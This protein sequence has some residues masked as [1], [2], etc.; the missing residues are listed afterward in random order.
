MTKKTAGKRS[1]TSEQKQALKVLGGELKVVRERVGFSQR[2]AAE[3]ARVIDFYKQGRVRPLTPRQWGR[4]ER[5]ECVPRPATLRAVVNAV[6]WKY[7]AVRE[8]LRP[9]PDLLE[10]A[11]LKKGGDP[12]GDLLDD[13]FNYFTE[14]QQL[15]ITNII[16]LLRFRS[17]VECEDILDF[18]KLVV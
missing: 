13:K 3:R 2:E 6:G 16:D 8:L 17:A 12:I 18:L 1:L 7:S 14:D 5:G 15:L 9:F 10:A 11:Q 4:L